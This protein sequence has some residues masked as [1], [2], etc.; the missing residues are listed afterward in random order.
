MQVPF[1]IQFTLGLSGLIGLTLASIQ[2]FYTG[3]ADVRWF[4]IQLMIQGVAIA[5]VFVI[6]G[7]SFWA[8]S[9]LVYGTALYA[10]GR[11]LEK[12]K[13][14]GNADTW[15]LVLLATSNFYS[16]YS[17]LVT[18]VL[19]GVPYAFY[20]GKVKG[21][22]IRFVPAFAAAQLVLFLSVFI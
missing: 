6:A 13:L 2:D 7:R 12:R 11:A 16:I 20:F 14:W 5:P 3:Y 18:L 1:L 22:E 19:F 8:V 4:W 9:M 21:E 17:I 15:A 10:S